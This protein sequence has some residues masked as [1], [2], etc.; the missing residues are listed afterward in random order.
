MLESVSRNLMDE[1]GRTARTDTVL[2]KTI[3][4]FD[5]IFLAI[6]SILATFAGS[7]YDDAMREEREHERL[8]QTCKDVEEN[9]EEVNSK[10]SRRS[11]E[12]LGDK[13]SE[14][15]QLKGEETTY[16]RRTLM[17]DFYFVFFVSMT[18]LVNAVSV[19]ALNTN[20][21]TRNKLLQGLME[22]YKDSNMTQYYNPSLLHNF[23]RRYRYFQLVVLG[24]AS[25]AVIVPMAI[26]MNRM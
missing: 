20:R 21:D 2:L 1:L 18:C 17:K 24:L 12:I 19:A 9:V 15:E 3:I 16:R 22:V 13:N 6:N 26:R 8:L 25:T 5:L 4:G 14:C 11:R 10:W 23:A 7:K